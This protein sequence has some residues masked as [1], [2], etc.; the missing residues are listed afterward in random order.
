MHRD[1]ET[2]YDRACEDVFNLETLNALHSEKLRSQDSEL[3][4]LRSAKIEHEA[5]I[6]YQ[7][8]RIKSLQSENEAYLR[9][10]AGLEQKLTQAYDTIEKN[11]LHIKESDQML[12]QLRLNQEA[13]KARIQCLESEKH[14]VEI[15]NKENVAFKEKYKQK[16]EALET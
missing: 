1:L 4:T 3:I 11:N 10:I 12:N 6:E 13:D 2:K 9:N 14:H 7:T 15:L 8:E 16:C 5:K